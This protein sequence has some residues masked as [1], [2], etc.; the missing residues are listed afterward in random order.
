M[1]KYFKKAAVNPF[2]KSDSG[3]LVLKGMKMPYSTE[4]PT[5]SIVIAAGGN[6][7]ACTLNSGNAAQF[8]FI[9]VS[10]KDAKGNGDTGVYAGG[11]IN[12]DTT[13][14]SKAYNASGPDASIEVVYKLLGQDQVLSY[15]VNL[16]SGTLVAG[17]TVDTQD[18]LSSDDRGAY[19][20]VAAAYDGGST[21]TTVTVTGAIGLVGYAVS[22]AL[23]GVEIATGTISTAG[24]VVMTDVAAVGAGTYTVRVTVTTAGAEYG[25]YQEVSM[26]V[27]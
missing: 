16:D 24:G 9:R 3:G 25:S 14:V 19:L 1:I 13:T 18:R 17:A 2:V 12:L 5:F 23:D 21:T 11:V 20:E 26:T 6:S 8:D 27:A 22:A 10:I 4:A 15:S 7:A